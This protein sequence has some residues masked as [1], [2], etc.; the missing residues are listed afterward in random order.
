MKRIESANLFLKVLFQLGIVLAM[1]LLGYLLLIVAYSIPISDKTMNE[2]M[3]Y[4]NREGGRFIVTNRENG[5]L[6]GSTDALMLLI[7]SHSSEDKVYKN[8]LKGA[9]SVVESSNPADALVR[10]YENNIHDESYEEREYARYWH[11]YVI[12]LRPLLYFFNYGHLRN[13]MCLLQLG[14][15]TGLIVVIS[16]RNISVVP[17]FLFWLSLN[18]ITTM[19]SLQ[20]STMTV[21]TFI[22]MLFV[23]HYSSKWEKKTFSWQIVFTIL[24]ALTSYFD[25]LTYPILS[26][27]APL[28]IYMSIY[29]Y[30]SLRKAMRKMLYFAFSWG[31]GYGMLWALKWILASIILGDNIVLDAINQIITRTSSDTGEESITIFRLLLQQI[32]GFYQVTVLFITILLVGVIVYRL[33]KKG[34]SFGQTIVCTLAL[35]AMIPMFWVCVTRN[36]AYLH[37]YITCRNFSI[38]IFSMASLAFYRKNR[39]ELCR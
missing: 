15:F 38:T 37:P 36:H 33:L 35:I 34:K 4:M 32:R 2:S 19:M 20:Y 12:F 30:N 6:D 13:I 17:L 1:A 7:A 9:Y 22:G 11:G 8:A 14:V 10:I 24:G 26:F 27:A 5:M 3:F 16:K 18:P 39:S 21:I 23:A 29:E 28:I 31:I 25:F